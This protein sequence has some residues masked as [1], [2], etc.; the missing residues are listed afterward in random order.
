MSGPDERMRRLEREAA[1][2]DPD[3]AEALR[4]MEERIPCANGHQGPWKP[5][6]V[7]QPSPDSPGYWAE[8]LNKPTEERCESCGLTRRFLRLSVGWLG[9][10]LLRAPMGSVTRTTLS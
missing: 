6:P 5:V 9:Y 7:D 8:P 3:A 2:G 1:A 10:P 4:G